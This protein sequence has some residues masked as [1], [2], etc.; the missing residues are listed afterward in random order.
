MA[1]QAVQVPALQVVSSA[2][3]PRAGVEH[4]EGSH[5][6]VEHAEG[7]RADPLRALYVHVPFCRRICP[8]CAF[9][10]QRNLPDQHKAYLNA[11]QQ[12]LRTVG[13]RW[14]GYPQRIETV[15]IGGGTPSVLAEEAVEQVLEALRAQFVFAERV[16]CS[17]E[18]NPEDL[19]AAQ[20]RAWQRAG[21]N[22]VSLGVQSLDAQA[23]RVL[24]RNHG[25]EEAVRALDLLA[26]SE[27]DSWNADLLWGAPRI[28]IAVHEKDLHH[29]LRWVPPHLSLY[30]LELEPSTP[31]G[32]S[33]WV[34]QALSGSEAERT[35]AWLAAV[36]HLR[37]EGYRQYEIS[38]FS[39]AG[40]EACQNLV[41]WEEGAYLG[42][43][44]GAH[45]FAA[46]RRWSH[47]RGF[48]EWSSALAAGRS[49]LAEEE[50]PNAWQRAS[51]SL[52]LALRRAEGFSPALWRE[53]YGY[54]WNAQQQR[55]VERLVRNALACWNKGQLCLT[56][57]G[58]LLADAITVELMPQAEQ[59]P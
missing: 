20:L 5:E 11:L 26:H 59:L 53:R 23:L 25:V 29:L 55:V 37:G 57:R 45:S 17:V 13:P 18:A 19:S 14:H 1:S 16:L 38:N 8:F 36:E 4:A 28:P 39:R 32:R 50:H 44:P 35:C 58:M 33:A 7:S 22:R 15:Y 24:G 46:G 6:R 3:A 9:A 49:S 47:L 41:V 21:V 10:V 40:H 54:A 2:E 56:P 12:E 52:M 48:H 43:G 30:L 42:F 27:L 34:R 51:E 31:F